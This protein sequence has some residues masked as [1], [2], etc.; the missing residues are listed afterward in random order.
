[1]LTARQM[2]SIS[3]TCLYIVVA[4]SVATAAA[5]G[6][7]VKNSNEK[8]PPGS[9]QL[10]CLVLD[11]RGNNLRAI[12]QALNGD[13]L[14]TELHDTNR[15]VGDISNENGKLTC[16]RSQAGPP[17]AYLNAFGGSAPGLGQ[18]PGIWAPLQAANWQLQHSAWSFKDGA[19]ENVWALAQTGD[20]FLW[21]GGSSGLYRFDG[22]EFALFHSPFGEELLSTDISCLY[23]PPSGGLWI[24]YLFGGASFLDRGRV[25]NY[26]GKFAVN[27][28][29][30]RLIVQD[31]D[32]IVWAAGL[33]S[34]LWRFEHSWEHVGTEWNV[35]IKSAVEAALDRD[36][37]LW[38]RG[39]QMLLRLRRGGQ[40]FELVQDNLPLNTQ[41][42]GYAGRLVD[43]EGSIWFSSHKG[44]DRFFYSP[45]VKQNIP[46]QP[47]G[48]AL[49]A[50][51]DGVVLVGGY[52]SVLYRVDSG[53]RRVFPKN[54]GAIGFIYRAPDGTI[55]LGSSSGLWHESVSHQRPS[56]DP[57]ESNVRFDVREALWR[58]TGRDWNM[59][60]LPSEVADYGEFLQAITQDRAGGMWLS[61]GR[62]GLYRLADGI[63]TPYGG[64]KDLPTTGVLSEFTDSLGRVWFGYTRNQ[65]AVLDGDRVQ[66]LGPSDGLR[67]GNVTA[68]YGRGP[69]IW[70]GGEFGLQ[71]FN[72]GHLKNITAINNE[73]LRGVSGIVETANGDLWLNGASGIFHIRQSELS[74]ALK[75]T[76]YQVNGDH[77]G[78]RNGLP[79]FATQLRPLPSAVEATDGRVWFA[80]SDGV[81]SLDPARSE[82]RAPAPAMTI[83]SVS[84]DDKTYEATF[85][86]RLPAHTSSVQLTYSAVSLSEPEAIR[87]RYKLKETDTDWQDAGQT[88]S[89]TYRSL[90]PGLYQFS[91]AATDTNG[92]WSDK[93]ATAE[94]T[95]LPAFYQTA[96]F[97]LLGVAALLLSL[98]GLYQLRLRRLAAQFNVRL[99]ER[100]SE[101]TRIA[102]ELHDTLLQSFQ[103]LLLR[104][105]TVSNLLPGGEPKQRLDAAIDHAAQAITEGRDAVQGLR[106][107][108]TV[109]N[110]LA[111]AVNAL[112][113]ELAAN[114]VSQN[115]PAFEVDVEGEPR[116][117]HPILRDEVYR[118]AGEA[119]RN[120]F[121]HAQAS[122]IEVEIHYDAHELRL[123]IRDDGKGIEP[124]VGGEDGR[125]GHFG[126]HGMR[127]RAKLIGGNLE[128]WSNVQSGTEIELTIPA[129]AAY[130]R[131]ATQR[132][133]WFARKVTTVKS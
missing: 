51:N 12:C 39:E 89:V 76:S 133:S 72:A 104:F 61:L 110:D 80:V 95:I 99:E 38:V 103:A 126:L 93:S 48:F 56:K 111:A 24:G 41:L 1:M 49:G 28:G 27:S 70:I 108:A 46:G 71:Q 62:H 83:Q 122:R 17:E 55:W 32:G 26:G 47:F 73:W 23:A 92:V 6:P 78:R 30:I 84:A 115:S 100:V 114:Q 109:T 132:R 64:R 9:Y 85:P 36:G 77:F 20:G 124:Q 8:V 65:L 101:R 14:T 125:A 128:L 68:I 82:H 52:S 97:R 87:F 127:E 79:G 50:A 131:P 121:R 59:F 43:Q 42:F 129:S 69:N 88:N 96:W 37:N 63:W 57:K 60:G 53:G 67:V 29:S 13:W 40:R 120:A 102:R 91:V 22:R 123:R 119:L 11:I 74:E 75:N 113:E 45:L 5:S 31:K 2:I 54:L 21:L 66:V 3:H 118:I 106:S 90:P 107:S 44:L 81:V 18:P 7:S 58:F 4:L 15:C 34:G 105:Q 25:K 117:L 130:T 98:W 35:P 86:L 94:F 116:D 16:N 33:S 19:P 10:T 112:G